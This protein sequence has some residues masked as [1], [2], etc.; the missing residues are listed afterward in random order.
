MN[1]RNGMKLPKPTKVWII[2]LFDRKYISENSTCK[3][4]LDHHVSSFLDSMKYIE[5]CVVLWFYKFCLQVILW[6]I[7]GLTLV[8]CA[9]GSYI[10]AGRQLSVV[11]SRSFGGVSP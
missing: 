6:G 9:D 2:I 4:N 3:L 10:F 7:L 8:P 11:S 1:P 5:I